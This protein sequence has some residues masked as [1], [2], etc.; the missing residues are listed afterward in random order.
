MLA[1]VRDLARI[2]HLDRN[3]L[4]A[5]QVQVNGRGRHD[6]VEGYVIL[7]GD[8]GELVRPDLIGD[9]AVGGDA[10]GAD[11]HEVDLA[12]LHKV[13]CRIVR[14]QGHVDAALHQFPRG[15][16]S[17]LQARA[18][19]VD[20]HMDVLALLVRHENDAERRAPIDGGKGAR[21]AVVQN[22]VAVVDERGAVLG[23]APVDDHVL[24]R[25]ALSLG[26]ER[27]AHLVGARQVFVGRDAPH[28][29]QRPK[30]VHGGGARGGERFGCLVQIGEQVAATLGAALQARQRHAVGGGSADGRRAADDHAFD[31]ACD[32]AIVV[33]A[34]DDQFV[35]QPPLVDH[36]DLVIFPENGAHALTNAFAVGANRIGQLIEQAVPI[37]QAQLMNEQATQHAHVRHLHDG[38]G[39]AGAR[40]L[41][42]VLQPGKLCFQLCCL[43]LVPVLAQM[44]DDLTERDEL[45]LS[46]G[47]REQTKTLREESYPRNSSPR[48][49]GRLTELAPSVSNE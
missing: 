1:D 47:R 41:I 28:A 6:W 44:M 13:A 15:E 20:Q 7:F 42:F 12:R 11:E 34:V 16:R 29:L 17:A 45:F 49:Y 18:C 36:F 22:R 24:V 43:A 5:F 23:H 38:V 10:I 3:V 33:V 37:V 40:S 8:H 21:I 48:R 30:E 19:L 35:R 32:L 9:I 46:H 14:N 31:R 2:A 4:P 26:D 39:G 25:E 27:R